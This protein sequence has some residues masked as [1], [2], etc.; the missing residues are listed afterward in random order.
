M[1]LQEL[2]QGIDFALVS[3]STDTEI[4]DVVYDSRNVV[5]GC[6][7]VCLVGANADGHEFAQAAAEKGAAAIVISKEI[8]VQGVT[9]IKTADTRMALAFMSAAYFGRPA[10]HLITIGITG[11]KGK[12]T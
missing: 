3:G 1:R 6:V 11:T 5:K 4:T 8:A 12:T 7:F 2:L 10:E 9:V